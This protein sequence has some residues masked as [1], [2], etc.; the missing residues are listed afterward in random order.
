[1]K[2]ASEKTRIFLPVT[3]IKMTHK[4]VLCPN[5]ISSFLDPIVLV[6]IYFSLSFLVR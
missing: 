5:D 1:M 6:R 2:R 4:S 3:M